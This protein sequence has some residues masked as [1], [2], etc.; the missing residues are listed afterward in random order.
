M[1][2]Y[3][4]QNAIIQVNGI[5]LYKAIRAAIAALPEYFRENASVVMRYE[6]YLNII[7]I[8]SI[9]SATLF[10]AQPE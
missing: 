7:E 8:L 10:D 9:G 1:S 4:T 5:S 3:S 2:I 6:D